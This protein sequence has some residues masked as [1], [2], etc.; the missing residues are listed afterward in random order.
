MRLLATAFRIVLAI[1]LG[2]ALAMSTVYF[3]P[4]VA[5]TELAETVEPVEPGWPGRVWGIEVERGEYHWSMDPAWKR[6]VEECKAKG[7]IPGHPGLCDLLPP[8]PPEEISAKE[9]REKELDET[10]EYLGVVQE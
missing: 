10:A 5:T 2:A 8:K 1:P 7:G 9:L 6:H 3:I 4:F